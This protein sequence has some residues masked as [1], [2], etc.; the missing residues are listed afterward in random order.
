MHRFL[1][2]ED[3]HS[4]IGLICTE[5]KHLSGLLDVRKVKDRF[6]FIMDS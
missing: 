3:F 2:I 1:L 5:L 6:D 4:K